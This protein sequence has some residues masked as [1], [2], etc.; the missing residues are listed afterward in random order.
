MKKFEKVLL[1]SDLDGTLL[2]TQGFISKINQEAVAYFMENGGTFGFATGR[3]QLNSLLFLE[4]I[5]VN[6]PCILYNGCGVYDFNT[7]HFLRLIELPKAKLVSFLKSCL[8]EF[9]YISIQVYAPEM[10]Y[11]ISPESKA[12]PY[13]V[14]THQPCEFCNIEEILDKTWIKILF[15]GE[16]ELLKALNN[17]MIE[18]SLEEELNW[19][20]S[21]DIFL[22]YLP[23]NVS[24][25]S[26]LQYVRELFGSGYKIYAVGDYN[27]DIEMIQLADVGIATQ[28]AV[29]S[30]KLVADNISVTNDENAI[31][32]IIY[33]FIETEV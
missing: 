16:Y 5:K 27:N 26:A 2:N 10:C 29:D 24:K 1:L 31:A 28:N 15:N 21:S 25:G 22:E 8:N 32:D 11:Y 3:N 20:F 30:L 17:K 12:D 6:A 7:N 4:E 23:K 13:I 14:E 18:Q 9:A 33:N 19:V